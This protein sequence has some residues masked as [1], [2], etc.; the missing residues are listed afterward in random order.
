MYLGGNVLG[1]TETRKV[2]LRKFTKVNQNCRETLEHIE[3]MA[4]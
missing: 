2:L 1:S 3:T 4:R